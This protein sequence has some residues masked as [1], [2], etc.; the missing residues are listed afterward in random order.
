M[1]CIYHKS[2]LDGLC[3]AAIIAGIF[4]EAELIGAGY[5]EDPDLTKIATGEKVFMVDY[6]L[7]PFEKMIAL[8]KQ[9]DLVWID[10]HKTAMDDCEKSGVA[11][12]GLRKIGL[13]ACALVWEYLMG[14]RSMPETVRLLAEYDVFNHTDPMTLPFQYGMRTNKGCKDPK[15]DTW[16][17][18][19]KPKAVSGIAESK[20]FNTILDSGHNVYEYVVQ[21][22][23]GSAKSMAFE[24]M[25]NNLRL[26]A[27]NRSDTGSLQFNSIWDDKKYDAMAIFTFQKSVW[28]VSLFTPPDSEVDVG[29]VAKVY[30]GGGHKGAAGFMCKSLPFP[31]PTAIEEDKKGIGGAN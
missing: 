28:S 12:K 11:F 7:Q 8:A 19:L 10:H 31:L 17:T 24:T 9:C 30:G 21:S 16:K 22:N 29:A 13:G 5:K 27:I 25:L 23:E 14:P 18:L 3:S 6:S 4:P 15:H 2:D 26:I 20:V 1:K